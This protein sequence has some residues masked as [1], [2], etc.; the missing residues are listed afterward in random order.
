MAPS[1]AAVT[2]GTSRWGLTLAGL[3][4]G[5][6]LYKLSPMLPPPVAL[7]LMSLWV[8]G[9]RKLS[10]PAIKE[11]ANAAD[12]RGARR[13]AAAAGDAAPGAKAAARKRK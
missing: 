10:M 2:A 3:I 13:A 4:A 8:F 12:N 11:S 5:I 6:M 9:M 1:A 7:G